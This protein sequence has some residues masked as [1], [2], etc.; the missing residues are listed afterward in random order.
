MTTAADLDRE[1]I[2]AVHRAERER[3]ADEHPRSRELFERARGSLVGGV[4]MT[5]MA[6]WVGGHPVYAASA[7]GASVTDVDGHTYV[8][9]S[10]GD[11][12]AMAGH[13]P[14]ATVAAV[15]RRLTEQG[16]ATLMLPTEDAA[17]VGEELGRRFGVPLWSFA[18]TATDA[19][20]WALRLCRAM[21]RRPYVL[22]F[23]HCYHGSV[24]ETFITLDA[25]ARPRSREGNVGPAVD[26]TV[27]TRVCEFNDLEAVHR[28][29]A[30]EQVACVLTEPALT[31]IGIVLPDD[32]FLA[33]VR[34]ACDQ[35]GTLLIIDE[36]HTLSAG[37]G[38]CT[39]AWGLAPDLV[40]IGKAIA[41]GIPI[42]AYGVSAEVNARIEALEDADLIDVGGVGGTLA[43]NPLSLA[44]ARATLAEVLTEGAF[45]RMVALCDHFVA[46]VHD[47]LAAHDVPWSIVQLG[48][49][50]ELAFAPE[51]PRSGGASAALHDTELEDA[52]HL[53]LLNR[54]IL[55]T[56]FHNMALMCPATTEADVDRHTA[57]FADA[58]AALAVV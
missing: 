55:I 48:A 45:A 35:T 18:L 21:T 15:E 29:L 8:D 26:P 46:G 5:W 44:A 7:R 36:T 43:G 30:D 6:K 20:R 11:T 10:L 58:V 24:D 25:N 9:F 34:A 42:G 39:A 49:R 3:F 38:G 1:R 23:S 54:G 33:G 14:P 57:V 41:G 4:P 51:P 16:G 53:F 13:S 56:P 32:G 50:A 19:N 52:L 12:G 27:T 40:T 28:L 37:P 17:A 22:V 31:N 2:A 47:V